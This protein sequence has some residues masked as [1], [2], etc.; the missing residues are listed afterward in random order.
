MHIPFNQVAKFVLGSSALGGASAIGGAG[1]VGGTI[2]S[3][4]GSTTQAQLDAAYQAGVAAALASISQ[5]N[6]GRTFASFNLTTDV[7]TQQLRVIT[8]GIWSGDSATLGTF[9]TSSAQTSTQKEYFYQV[10]D[11]NPTVSGSAQ[12]FGVAYGNRLGSGS[13]S[14]A[15]STDNPTKAIYSQ[16]KLVAL[17]PGDTVFTFNSGSTTQNSDQIYALTINRARI[18]DSLDPGNW[19]LY[20]A[21][22]S[23]SA[24]ANNVHTGSNVKVSGTGAVV[25][26]IDDSSL[27]TAVDVTNSG[28]K[29]N[30]ISGTIAGGAYTDGAG[31]RHNYGFVYPALGLFIFNGLALNQYV[32]FN[33]VTGSING[34]NAFKLFT[35]ISGAAAI[36]TSYVFSARNNQT[37]VASNY[38]VRLRNGDFNYSNNPTFIT[39]SNSQVANVDFIS[40]PNVYVTTI[41]LYNANYDM[42]AVAKLS[43]PIL[44]NFDTELLIKVKLQY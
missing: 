44:K 34:D 5:A 13:N 35:S 17:S 37:T 2:S 33:S 39:G 29:Y 16:M 14:T 36:N 31:N 12:Q 19:Q 38:F 7:V 4:G 8:K 40:D 30:I 42:L 1:A 32:G 24:V 18:K 21:Q 43:R 20:L 26:L 11:G 3:A 22:L 25:S 6:L 27:T 23:G 15:S 28:P 9:F 41:G 10:W